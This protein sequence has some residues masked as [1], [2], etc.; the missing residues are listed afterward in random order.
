MSFGEDQATN[1]TGHDP[2]NLATLRTAIID[3]L[4]NAG[5]LHLPEDHRN[6]HTPAEALH[7]HDLD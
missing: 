4:K 5:N 3:T 7:L 1:H 6:H 2:I